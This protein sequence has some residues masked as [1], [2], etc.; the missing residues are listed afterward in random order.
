MTALLKSWQPPEFSNRVVGRPLHC[1][2]LFFYLLMF[3]DGAVFPHPLEYGDNSGKQFDAVTV[4][5]RLAVLT[6]SKCDIKYL[7]MT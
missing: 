7:V 6:F 1:S 5:D 3:S 2:I 4:P